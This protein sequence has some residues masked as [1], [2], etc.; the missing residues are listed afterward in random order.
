MPVFQ[1]M[2]GSFRVISGIFVSSG[3]KDQLSTTDEGGSGLA[4]L[5]SFREDQSE[6]AWG[7]NNSTRM[8]ENTH[9]ETGDESISPAPGMAR[10]EFIRRV[11]AASAVAGPAVTA[12]GWTG[13]QSQTTAVE[14]A[15]GGRKEP[16]VGI[17]MSPHS[18]LDEGIERCLD[19][20]QETA[21]VNAILVYSHLSLSEM[22]GTRPAKVVVAPPA[23]E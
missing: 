15:T 9:P 20:I 12:T 16:F 7:S 1:A 5:V 8:D 6:I 17:Q 10:R 11:V 14:P 13:A 4:T 22:L 19:L 23:I 3:G 2:H 21:G 18:M